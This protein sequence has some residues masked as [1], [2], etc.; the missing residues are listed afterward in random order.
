MQVSRPMRT[1]ALMATT[2]LYR[3]GKQQR[4]NGN[5]QA[6][7]LLTLSQPDATGYAIAS[8]NGGGFCTY[9]DDTSG[10][11][12]DAFAQVIGASYGHAAAGS[13]SGSNLGQVSANA[14]APVA[15]PASAST[16]TSIG[17]SVT[18]GNYTITASNATSEAVLM[19]TGAGLGTLTETYGYG[20]F[21]A[22]SGGDNSAYSGNAQFTFQTLLG[23]GLYLD[24][25]TW[26]SIG[27]AFESLTF[28]LNI[29]AFSL[30]E[31]FTDLLS[32]ETF[33]DAEHFLGN[34][35]GDFETAYIS[36]SVTFDEPGA[37]FAFDYRIA[38][39][40]SVEVSPVPLPASVQMLLAALCAM[41]VMV[42]LRRKQPAAA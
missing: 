32:F 9:C 5:A 4:A 11:A 6:T 12:A 25:L 21:S 22:G 33:F 41:G 14:V 20:L 1:A 36:Y 29:G 37:G 2:V 3:G 26:D 28:S 23:D 38:N 42:R 18:P 13:Q 24:F 35:T 40:P 15:S 19:P 16:H 27:A 39:G 10:G 31:T 17:T 7:A 30:N 8:A 34:A